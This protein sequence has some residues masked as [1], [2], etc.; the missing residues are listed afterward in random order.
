MCEF[1]FESWKWIIKYAWTTQISRLQQVY[2]LPWNVG[3]VVFHNI[4]C[5]ILF[6]LVELVA[7]PGEHQLNWVWNINDRYRKKSTVNYLRYENKLL[8]AASCWKAN[9][10]YFVSD[11]KKILWCEI[12]GTCYW[13]FGKVMFSVISVCHSVSQQRGSPCDHYPFYRWTVIGQ[14]GSSPKYHS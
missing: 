4:T 1:E 11:I 2:L 14:I 3:F 5:G 13:N 7:Q 8:N 9:Q 6:R 12:F 10:F